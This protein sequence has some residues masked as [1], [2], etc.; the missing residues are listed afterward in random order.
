MSY[1]MPFY[2]DD[3]LHRTSFET[4]EDITNVAMIFPSVMKY[5]QIWGGRAVSM[6]LIQLMLMLPRWVY[7]VL[8]GLIYVAIL[9]VTYEYA[10]SAGK[11]SVEDGRLIV[12]SF[13]SFLLWFFMPDFEGVVTWTTGT[14]TYLWMNLIILVFGLWYYRDY[15]YKIGRLNPD[16]TH[17]D[18]ASGWKRTAGFA[19]YACLGLCA[20]MSDEAGACALMLGLALY[21]F[22]LL[23]RHKPIEPA[24]WIGIFSCAAG[25]GLLMLAPGNRVRSAAASGA[26]EAGAS[27]I[28]VGLHR[29]GRETFYTLLYLT[30]P[31]AICLILW[32]LAEKKKLRLASMI[33]D[34][35]AGGTFMYLAL[36]FVSIYV[37]TFASG[38]ADRIFQFPLLMITIAAG[39]SL[40]RLIS[41]ATDGKMDKTVRTAV[42]IAVLLLLIMVLTEVT[43]GTLYACQSGTFFDRK[44]LLYRI[45]DL[46]VDG[47]MPGN[48][49]SR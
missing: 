32:V 11:S 10:R 31:V 28:S 4:G 47:L 49:I 38:F 29:V 14:V 21:V 24:K 9:N 17:D 33:T 36:A 41:G 25:F 8:N 43:A 42:E 12:T 5:Y 39:I 20:G 18:M 2:T 48:G 45:D 15:L 44:M 46:A 1:L 35:S 30:I 6:F 23:K 27:L 22:I 37:M 19:G 16:V 34:I 13:I 40:V 7:A 3:Y 26:A